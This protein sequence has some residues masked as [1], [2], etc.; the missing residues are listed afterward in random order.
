[1]TF[2]LAKPL[3]ANHAIILSRAISL[4]IPVKS[5]E[6]IK[7]PAE[8]PKAAEEPK[9]EASEKKE[10]A[11]AEAPKTEEK[12]AETPKAEE[13]AAEK[14]AEAAKPETA[15]TP[16]AEPAAAGTTPPPATPAVASDAPQEDSFAALF[17]EPASLGSPPSWL[18]WVVLL[19]VSLVLGV[20][21]YSLTQRNLRSWLNIETS[22]SP[23]VSAT[24]TP[25]ATPTP[26]ESATATP[27]PTPTA[28]AGI[29][30]KTVTLRILNGT[31]TA[32][33]ASKAK[34]T[35]E[36]AGFSVRTIGNA[37]TQNYATTMVYYK[38]GRKAEAEAVQAALAGYTATLEQSSL[39]DPDM[40]LVI[41]GKK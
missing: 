38:E 37:A 31:T 16:P 20:V 27:T 34:T 39:A 6:S 1:L 10:E 25:T 28:T 9:K 33:A 21:G 8:A 35:V 24:A 4:L 5:P 2:S 41:I 22:P 19:I 13:K 14:P 36:K 3:P 40:V 30:A 29:D 23:T 15:A 7:T 18:W 26:T 11:P 32:G 12:P 17:P